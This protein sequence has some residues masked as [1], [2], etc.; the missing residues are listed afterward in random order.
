MCAAQRT[1]S[2]FSWWRRVQVL[3]EPCPE[4]R[5]LCSLYTGCQ[6]QEANSAQG[7]GASQGPQALS[8]SGLWRE[9]GPA[10]FPRSG[11]YLLAWVTQPSC[12]R[13]LTSDLWQ[14]R[15]SSLPPARWG[16]G[17]RKWLELCFFFSFPSLPSLLFFLSSLLFPLCFTHLPLSASPS[18][19]ALSCPLSLLSVLSL[20]PCFL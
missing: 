20:F 18:S 10:L 19:I 6:D 15:R 16:R 17:S 14:K 7:G 12:S 1:P 2:S 13:G 9:R 3:Q 8:H 4:L 11:R 5:A